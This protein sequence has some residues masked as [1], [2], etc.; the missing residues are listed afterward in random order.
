MDPVDGWKNRA[1]ERR[2]KGTGQVDTKPCPHGAVTLWID[3]RRV[4]T[5]RDGAVTECLSCGGRVPVR[6]ADKHRAIPANAPPI[7]TPSRW[8]RLTNRASRDAT[9]KILARIHD[10]ETRL[11]AQR[12]ELAIWLRKPDTTRAEFRPWMSRPTDAGGGSRVPRRCRAAF[13]PSRRTRLPAMPGRRASRIA[14]LSPHRPSSHT[15]MSSTHDRA[16]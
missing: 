1:S 10:G 12:D 2:G 11:Q 13:A 3:P 5:D 7:I 16:L 6:H 15:S 14:A 9:P 8:H 4:D